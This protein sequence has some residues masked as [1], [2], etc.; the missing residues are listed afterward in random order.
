M[1]PRIGKDFVRWTPPTG[2]DETL[3][4]VD[5]SI[6]PHVD[7]EDMPDNSMAGAEAWAAG[8]SVPAY[9]IDDRDRHQ[10]DRRHRRRRLRGALEAVSPLTPTLHMSAN[11]QTSA[12]S[13]I[14][15]HARSHQSPRAQEG[16]NAHSSQPGRPAPRP[17]ARAG[18]GDGRRHRGRRQRVR[19][20]VPQL[21]RHQGGGAR[22]G[23]AVG[24]PGL[25]GSA[26]RPARRRA[27]PRVARARLLGHRVQRR[28]RW[29]RTSLRTPT[30]SGRASRWRGTARRC[31]TRRS[32]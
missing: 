21:L 19:A 31:S 26:A 18:R 27:D 7:H 28:G 13:A 1:T 15:A 5:F 23:L 8:M 20:D 16:G 25:R 17:R 22:R 10:G 29:R 14:C 6:F 11:L 12:R 3:G 32:A 2:G 24:V 4:L 9:A 30:C